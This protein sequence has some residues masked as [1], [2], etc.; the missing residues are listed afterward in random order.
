MRVLKD[1]IARCKQL[2]INTLQGSYKSV[3]VTALSNNI[4]TNGQCFWK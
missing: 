4:N 1:W 3:D 2:V